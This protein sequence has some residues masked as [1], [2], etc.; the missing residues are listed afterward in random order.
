MKTQTTLQLLTLVVSLA[1]AACTSTGGT[2]AQPDRVYAASDFRDVLTA[3][4][5]VVV[6]MRAEVVTFQQTER[7]MAAH[8]EAVLDWPAPEPEST[9]L[10]VHVQPTEHGTTVSVD[11]EWFAAYQERQSGR[12]K[13]VDPSSGDCMACAAA[14]DASAQF[15]KVSIG[16]AMANGRRARSEILEALDQQLNA[17]PK[18]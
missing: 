13:S 16:R 7:P 4:S 11:T 8:L 9:V 1:L 10:I 18:A 15:V 12:I 5:A 14:K 2:P 3:L 6:D 17:T